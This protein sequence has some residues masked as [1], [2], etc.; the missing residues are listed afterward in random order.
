MYLSWTPNGPQVESINNIYV[1]NSSH[2]T[3]H[4]KWW[5]NPTTN[6][7]KLKAEKTRPGD[8]VMPDPFG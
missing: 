1:P 3:R 5:G 7:K 6:N 4:I 8:L 2:T